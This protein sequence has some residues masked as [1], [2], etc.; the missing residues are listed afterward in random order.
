MFE[1]ETD[2]FCRK[3]PIREAGIPP[4]AHCK[5]LWYPMPEWTKDFKVVFALKGKVYRIVSYGC[6]TNRGTNGCHFW[7]YLK[8][9]EVDGDPWSLPPAPCSKAEVV[10]A[11]KRMRSL[12]SF[13]MQRG[14]V[15]SGYADAYL[16]GAMRM[17]R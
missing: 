5:F 8:A 2:K 14:M 13:T 6:G 4:C 1:L 10:D 11:L 7:D 12:P 3:Y 15:E 16:D 9:E 17:V